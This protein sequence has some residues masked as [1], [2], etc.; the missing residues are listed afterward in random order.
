MNRGKYC[1]RH[2]RDQNVGICRREGC[3]NTAL[4]GRLC[5]RHQKTQRHQKNP[6]AEFCSEKG[7]NNIAIK[8]AP[9]YHR[10]AKRAKPFKLKKVI[11]EEAKLKSE[12]EQL[13]SRTLEACHA[14]ISLASGNN[15][16]A[17]GNGVILSRTPRQ[18]CTVLDA[19]K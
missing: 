15:A 5:S 17:A 8:G 7:C 16:S 1:V 13:K 19:I 2:E 10:H 9:L 12:E 14:L 4:R 11:V 6:N 18:K 3:K